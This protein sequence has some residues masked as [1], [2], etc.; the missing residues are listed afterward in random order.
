[1]SQRELWHELTICDACRP[2]A[3]ESAHSPVWHTAS[4][5]PCLW[6]CWFCQAAQ[7][8]WVLVSRHLSLLVTV[9]SSC[10]TDVYVN[11]SASAAGAWDCWTTAAQTG[12]SHPSVQQAAA[13]QPHARTPVGRLL[14]A[15]WPQWPLCYHSECVVWAMSPYKLCLRVFRIVEVI[16]EHSES[17]ECGCCWVCTDF[18]LEGV[19]FELLHIYHI[20]LIVRWYQM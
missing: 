9:L 19:V 10:K 14:P 20:Y 11:C 18:P 3:A 16:P 4:W 13:V 2:P 7:S 5:L 17:S 1:M 15:V 8:W 12:C 6:P